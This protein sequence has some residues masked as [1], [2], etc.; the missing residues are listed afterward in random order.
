[1]SS[2]PIHGHRHAHLFL[3]VLFDPSLYFFL[4]SFFLLFL[5]PALVPDENSMEDPLCTPFSG[6]WSAWTMSH[7][8]QLRYMFHPKEHL[9]QMLKDLIEEAV[10]VDLEPKPASLWWTS[11]YDS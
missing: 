8:T 3:S 11:T 1:M 4:K 9:E 10:K 2:F 7:P 5:N 6:A